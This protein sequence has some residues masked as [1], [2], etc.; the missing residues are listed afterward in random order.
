MTRE[1]RLRAAEIVALEKL[2][3]HEAG[4]AAA[5]LAQGLHVES[6]FANPVD[7]TEEPEDRDEAA[8]S[9]MVERPTDPDGMRKF[10][11]SVICGR[12]EEGKAAWPPSW[13]LT[14]VPD[15]GD[16]EQL[17]ELVK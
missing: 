6:V 12:L 1:T 13:P 7:L 5:A 2:I 4:H 15:A 14:L 9:A 17:C 10:A 3:E 8:G 16:E 11:I